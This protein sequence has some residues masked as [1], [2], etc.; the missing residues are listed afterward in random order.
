M[1]K[2]CAGIYPL[3]GPLF[4]ALPHPSSIN[5]A[6]QSQKPRLLSYWFALHS[7]TVAVNF[8]ISTICWH[9]LSFIAHFCLLNPYLAL[10]F[11]SL[12]LL[13]FFICSPSL[14][15]MKYPGN[16]PIQLTVQVMFKLSLSLSA[17]SPSP[18]FSWSSALCG[19]LYAS[20][21]SI[22]DISASL[23][24]PIRGCDIVWLSI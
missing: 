5:M 2:W 24:C 11:I 15:W 21:P 6:I 22:K 16:I 9:S 13:L 1:Y 3:P 19:E 14:I 18:P 12:S 23:L 7:L 4:I 17:Y 20:N 8:N 10:L